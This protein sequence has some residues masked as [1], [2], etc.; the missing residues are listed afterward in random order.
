[1]SLL[2]IGTSKLLIQ[3]AGGAY[4][5]H[6]DTVIAGNFDTLQQHKK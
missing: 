5:S 6:G 4:Q 3:E 2:S 1:M